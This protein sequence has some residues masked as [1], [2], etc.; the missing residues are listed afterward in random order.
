MKKIVLASTSPFRASLLEKLGCPF[1][2]ASPDC[3]ETPIP[4]ESHRALVMRLAK[5]KAKSV[6]DRFP[7]SLI[8]GSDQVAELGQKILGKPGDHATATE[9]LKSSS[10]EA[11]VFHTGLCLFD[12]GTGLCQLDEI[13]FRVYFRDLTDGQI[14]NYLN[15]EKP[16]NCA[17]S[18]KSEGMG[19]TLFKKLEGDDPNALV[20]LPLIRLCDMLAKCEISLP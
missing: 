8:I 4:G 9:Q 20:G 14:E 6:A 3:D 18:F 2:T 16:Y 5:I 19:I 10:G 1:E 17:G 11:V 7:D 13:L 15:A 12:S